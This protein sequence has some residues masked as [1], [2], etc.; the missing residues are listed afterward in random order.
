MPR[1]GS[2]QDCVR[3]LHGRVADR[4]QLTLMSCVW[5]LQLVFWNVD[6]IG[7]RSKNLIH[8]PVS[9][10]HDQTRRQQ[11]MKPVQ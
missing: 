9:C 10:Q 11:G 4:G 2:V 1:I 6:Q 7:R 5:L 3:R 8:Y